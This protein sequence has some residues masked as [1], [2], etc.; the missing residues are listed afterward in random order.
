MKDDPKM[1]LID[2]GSISN[3]R[4]LGNQNSV[5]D[6]VILEPRKKISKIWCIAVG[7]NNKL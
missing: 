3:F 4:D 7:E 6:L 5:K 1:S 2:E